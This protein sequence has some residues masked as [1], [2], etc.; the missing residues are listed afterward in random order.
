MKSLG[1][2]NMKLFSRRKIEVPD[3]IMAILERHHA[4]VERKDYQTLRSLY[5][6]DAILHSISDGKTETSSI[7]KAIEH[8][9]AN[10]VPVKKVKMRYTILGFES[11]ASAVLRI[12][13]NEKLFYDDEVAN[14]KYDEVIVFGTDSLITEV[15][16]TYT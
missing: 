15:T 10:R 1:P 8:L 2:V 13:Y 3:H 5:S 16:V 14:L 6:S 12:A 7:K 9:A 4:A 11:E